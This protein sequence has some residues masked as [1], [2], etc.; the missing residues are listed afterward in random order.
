ML[1][2]LVF[3]ALI[4]ASCTITLN[5]D[6][7]EDDE[8]YTVYTY[9]GLYA[10]LVSEMPCE[11][12]GNGEDGIKEISSSA[13]WGKISDWL[14]SHKNA[15]KHSWNKTAINAYLTGWGF[16]EEKVALYAD[17]LIEKDHGMCYRR[18]NSVMYFLI[19]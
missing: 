11:I 16:D 14:D 12:V 8:T 7:E 6:E 19:K 4:F 1:A 9:S 15:Q 10:D 2:F 17:W 3:S 18:Q 5:D 13:D